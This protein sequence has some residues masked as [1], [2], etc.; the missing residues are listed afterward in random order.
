MGLTRPQLAELM[1]STYPD[2]GTG[3]VSNYTGQ[4]WNFV[5]TISPGDIVVVPLERS[6]TFRVAQVT[7]KAETHPELSDH[8][9]TRQVE[10]LADSV[11]AG[12][13]GKICE[14]RLARS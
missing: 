7:G 1:A 5:N 2:S 11:P 14:A 3:T 8:S 6:L 9:A 12:R 4:V 10:W 13:L